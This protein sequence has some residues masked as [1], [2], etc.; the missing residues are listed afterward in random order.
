LKCN[1]WT[2]LLKLRP[3]I[4][5]NTQ[6]TNSDLGDDMA[7]ITTYQSRLDAY[8]E[9]KDP[10][11]M[12]S[13]T[14]A[15]LTELIAGVSLEELRRRPLPEKWSVTEILAHL[16]EDELASSWRYRQMIENN[17]C[18]LA[19]FDQ[20][21]WARLGHYSSWSPA[22]ALQMFRLLW[23]AN[24]RM[25]NQLTNEEWARHGMHA[26]RGEISVRDLARHMAGHDMN[27][28]E[29]IRTILGRS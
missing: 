7:H 17:G 2:Y 28:V 9:G 16:A 10:L 4:S 25:L 26:E 1:G 14:P 12:Q 18:A 20:D 3:P 6:L 5:I 24:L 8:T 11:E 19:G 22:D 27:H 13:R 15:L 29:Q 21:K 23:E